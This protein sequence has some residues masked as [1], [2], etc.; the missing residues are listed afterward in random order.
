MKVFSCSHETLVE[1]QSVQRNRFF[2]ATCTVSDR[3]HPI[4]LHATTPSTN[5]TDPHH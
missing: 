2:N 1:I 3:Y 5:L 4:N